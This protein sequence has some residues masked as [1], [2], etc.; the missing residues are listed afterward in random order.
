MQIE[1]ELTVTIR[2]SKEHFIKP[3]HMVSLDDKD[4]TELVT[5]G[6]VSKGDPEQA[7]RRAFEFAS[8]IV[9]DGVWA[10]IEQALDAL[11]GEGR[12]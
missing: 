2:T 4:M 5:D 9:R 3:R 10:E 7:L 8:D 11:E 6:I 1:C 12:G